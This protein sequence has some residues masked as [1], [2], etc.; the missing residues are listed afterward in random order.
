MTIKYLDSDNKLSIIAD[1][2][3][4]F[5]TNIADYTGITI[6][7]NISCLSNS[8]ELTVD[9]TDILDDT[10]NVYI[11]DNVL[12][13]KPEL[14]SGMTKFVDGIYKISLKFV[15]INSGG[16]VKITNCIFVDITFKCKLASLIIDIL[17]ENERGTE[18]VSTIAHILHYAL[19]N[20]SNCGCNC[21][22]MCEVFNALKNLLTGI[23]VKTINDCGC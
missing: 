20:G 14:F 23:D 17:E 1:E 18:K 22:E 7:A 13:I 5:I 8:N 4:N 11:E 2:I 12:Y 19:V 3:N 16:Y 6:N 9:T 21:E 15:K 10:K